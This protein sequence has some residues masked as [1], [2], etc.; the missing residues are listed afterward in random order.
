M[1]TWRSLP[2]FAAT[3]DIRV[4]GLC[5]ARLHAR[6]DAWRV[7]LLDGELTGPAGSLGDAKQEALRAFAEAVQDLPSDLRAALVRPV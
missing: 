3:A 7:Q 2:G 1:I 5:I 6:R 4:R